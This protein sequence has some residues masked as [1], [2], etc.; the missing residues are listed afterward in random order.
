MRFEWDERKRQ[1]NLAKHGLDFLDV[2][3]VFEEPH[4]VVPSAYEGGEDRFLPIGGFGGAVGDS[5]LH[6][7]QRGHQDYILSEGTP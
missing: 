5:R 4:I 6:H 1:S 7:P 2:S 3:A